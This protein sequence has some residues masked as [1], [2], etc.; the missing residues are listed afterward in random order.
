M[1]LRMRRKKEYD[2]VVTLKH[3][4]YRIYNI[5][6]IL[7]CVLTIAA[8]IFALLHTLFTNIMWVN[9]ALIGIILFNFITAV[10]NA[11]ANVHVAIFKWAL[12]ASAFLWLLSPLHVPFISVFFII[13]A[14]LERQIKFPQ[15]I[16]FSIEGITFNTFPFK[17]YNWQQ[18]M[19]V[20]L[21]DNILTI[22]LK[23]NRILQKETESDI[24]ATTEREFNDYC[25]T[26]LE[27][28]VL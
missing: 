24:D 12:Y 22:D 23:N 21:K 9:M 3:P 25:T 20:L 6:S 17:N 19:N 4:D 14:L 1:Q 5:I 26:Q 13:A 11:R 10:V 27:N 7:M 18:V 15:E 28:K 8:E 16:G 2:F